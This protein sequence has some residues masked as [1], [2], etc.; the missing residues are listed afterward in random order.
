ME[1]SKYIPDV[2]RLGGQIYVKGVYTD[3][4][5]GA[6]QSTY[7]ELR[8]LYESSLVTEC[9]GVLCFNS[10]FMSTPITVLADSVRYGHCYQNYAVA[11][12]NGKHYIP[13]CSI[14]RELYKMNILLPDTDSVLC[15]DISRY[16][17]NDQ[18]D[19]PTV[20]DVITALSEMRADAERAPRC[21]ECDA[22]AKVVNEHELVVI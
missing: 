12:D 5:T 1:K 10:T 2:Y 7:F 19:N 21:E 16:M 3:Q 22:A 20:D 14:N 13:Y 9:E 6:I 18:C 11:V 8:S 17:N 4:S 15:F